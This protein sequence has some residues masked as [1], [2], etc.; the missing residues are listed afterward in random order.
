M[1]LLCKKVVWAKENLIKNRK[2]LRNIL[3]SF[4]GS[5]PSNETCKVL[6][7]IKILNIKNIKVLW[8]AVKK[9]EKKHTHKT[10]KQKKKQKKRVFGVRRG[11]VSKKQAHIYKLIYV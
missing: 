4:G 11:A 9:E 5:D 3:I 6:E 2:Q 1:F 7:A 10:K 8:N